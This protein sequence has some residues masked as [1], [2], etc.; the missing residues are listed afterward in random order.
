M[1]VCPKRCIVQLENLN[2]MY[3]LCPQ[4]GTSRTNHV[5]CAVKKYLEQ[6]QKLSASL[7]FTS[8]FCNGMLEESTERVEVGK[9]SIQCGYLS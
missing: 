4:H 5:S 8:T 7:S 1:F 9:Q 6:R 2:L 3:M